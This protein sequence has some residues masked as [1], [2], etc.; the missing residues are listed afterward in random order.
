MAPS[1]EPDEA[2]CP[3]VASARRDGA[4]ALAAALEFARACAAGAVL[5][6]WK[7]RRLDVEAREDVVQE[8]LVRVLH[9][10]ART[11]ARVEDLQ[12][13]VRGTVELILRERWKQLSR[14]HVAR[15]PARELEVRSDD[16]RPEEVLLASERRALV[17][18]CLD[19]LPEH[20]RRMLLL[21]YREQCTNA[22]VAARLGKTEKAVERALPRALKLVRACLERKKMAP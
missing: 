5:V 8:T 3:R 14:Q 4:D 15:D 21:R 20:H 19:G 7:G 12:D 2:L 13:W 16:A 11:E 22:E 17:L 18:E 9:R 10:I 1:S 6:N